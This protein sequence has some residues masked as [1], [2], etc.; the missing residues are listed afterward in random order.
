[1]TSYR[2]YYYHVTRINKVRVGENHTVHENKYNFTGLTFLTP[3]VEI[4]LFEKRNPKVS[5]N[6]YRVKLLKKDKSDIIY[7]FR[8]VDEEK[9]DH[10]DLLCITDNEKSHFMYIDNFSRLARS[11]KTLHTETLFTCKKCFTSFNSI[12]KIF[13]LHGQAALDEHRCICD[14]HKPIR[15]LPIMP[16]QRG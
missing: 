8:V 1:M 13:K 11:Q 7:P 2:Y 15:V 10:F 6:I 12:P 4:D 16:T 5:V 9:S 14:P 3:L